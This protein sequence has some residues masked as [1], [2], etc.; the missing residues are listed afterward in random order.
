[1]RSISTDAAPKPVAAY[2]QGVVANGFLFTAGQI[3]LDPATNSLV[4]G[5]EAQA[6]RALENIRAVLHAEG[7]S[8]ADVVKF[9]LYLTDLSKFGAIN[10]LY[11]RF[12]D[13]HRPARTTVGVGSL[14][15]GAL[16][17]VDAVAV[18]RQ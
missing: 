17:E 6:Q 16:F 7:L 10:A 4:E 5:L 2:S 8:V 1:M 18:A 15:A 13:G 9:T 14:P 3:G 11:E 12:L